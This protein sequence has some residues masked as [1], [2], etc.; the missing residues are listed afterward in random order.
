M[1][2]LE[3]DTLSNLQDPPYSVLLSPYTGGCGGKGS[4][5]AHQGDIGDQTPEAKQSLR[6]SLGTGAHV[7]M[8]ALVGHKG[9]DHTDPE[10]MEEEKG[11]GW[12]PGGAPW[13]SAHTSHLTWAPL[14]AARGLS[15]AGRP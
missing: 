9:N 14:T 8:H 6:H 3:R 4:L 7:L 10:G 1:G 13:A 15:A 12:M 11:A 2:T 5:G